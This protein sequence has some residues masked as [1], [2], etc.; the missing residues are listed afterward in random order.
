M[1]FQVLLAGLFFY[2]ENRIE[3]Q[4]VK[5]LKCKI[6]QSD[7]YRRNFF[8][9]NGFGKISRT[10]DICLFVHPHWGEKKKKRFAFHRVDRFHHLEQETLFDLPHTRHFFFSLQS[11]NFSKKIILA[12]TF[13]VYYFN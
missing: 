6:S 7:T 10:L 2:A 3:L 12:F 1:L 4:I 11:K 9:L 5:V 8:V 13:T